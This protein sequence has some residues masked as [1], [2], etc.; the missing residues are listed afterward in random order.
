MDEVD[1]Y[2]EDIRT[3]FGL[4]KPSSSEYPL[5]LGE[6]TS[7][8]LQNDKEMA[9]FIEDFVLDSYNIILREE[10]VPRFWSNFGGREE[11]VKSGR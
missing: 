5:S 3:V 8:F 6:K 7:I 1:L 9:E 10:I 2:W 4:T 11:N